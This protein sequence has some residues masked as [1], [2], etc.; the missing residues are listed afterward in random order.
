MA[1]KGFELVQLANNIVV[2]AT[3]TITTLDIDPAS[4]AGIPQN[5]GELPEHVNLYYTDA[6]ADARITAATTTD[7]TE[8]TNLYFTDERVDDR[9]SALIVGGNNI[10]STYDDTAGTLTIDGQPGY[11]NSDV[12]TYLSTNGYDT[13]TNI[14]ASITDSAPGTLDTLNEL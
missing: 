5:T 2:D 10:T 14:V 11:T 3:G 1:S 4:I 6:R 8:G 7:L 13:A 12:G 9:I